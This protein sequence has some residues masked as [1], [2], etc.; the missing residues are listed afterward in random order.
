MVP[1]SGFQ[2]SQP[3]M[4]HEIW[5]MKQAS[6]KEV[7]GKTIFCF[8]CSTVK[9]VF[10]RTAD[11][12]LLQNWTTGVRGN[13]GLQRPLGGGES[14]DPLEQNPLEKEFGGKWMV[15]VIDLMLCMKVK[16]HCGVWWL[17]AGSTSLLNA[18]TR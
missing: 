2:A 7:I 1:C 11:V 10:E 15:F 3:L 13:L 6:R 16:Y 9:Q 18:I 8:M 14:Q 17:S 5:Q 4:A 12:P